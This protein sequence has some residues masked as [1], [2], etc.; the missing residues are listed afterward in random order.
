MR[1]QKSVTARNGAILIEEMGHFYVRRM[2]EDAEAMAR[3]GKERIL[4]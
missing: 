2:R 3:D 4:L 1:T